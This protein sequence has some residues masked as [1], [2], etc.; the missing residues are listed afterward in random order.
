MAEA[1]I[2]R[3]V[4]G[5][6]EL[7]EL[8]QNYLVA[9]GNTISAG[10]F[11][12]FVN[13]TTTNITFGNESDFHTNGNISLGE[14][15]AINNSQVLVA[16]NIGTTLGVAKIGTISGSSISWG[17]QVTF[18]NGWTS[19]ISCDVMGSRVVISF[20]ALN[21]SSRGYTVAGTIS[22]SSI[23]FGSVQ[24]H[25]GVNVA[26]EN[27]VRLTTSNQAVVGWYN[28]SSQSGQMR[29]VTISG[30][31]VSFG[32]IENFGSTWG[33]PK[34]TVLSSNKIALVRRIRSFSPHAGQFQ[35]YTISGTNFTYQSDAIFVAATSDF[36]IQDIITISPTKAVVLYGDN[37]LNSTMA[38]VIEVSPSNVLTLGTPVAYVSGTR[39]TKGVGTSLEFITIAYSRPNP[40]TSAGF[41]IAGNITGNS[42]TFGTE[43]L[44][45]SNDVQSL[46]I[47]QINNTQTVLAYVMGSGPSSLARSRVRTSQ[48]NVANTNAEKVSG[49][50]KTGGTAGQTI[51]V[52][53][54]T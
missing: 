28:N 3:R 8:F 10:T 54:N 5:G 27:S 17:N 40:S 39:N 35:V 41:T 13:N 50:A 6:V 37:S 24:A 31:N 2:T 11:V 30:N 9:A 38:R 23:T 48:L 52:Y 22:G 45:N 20:T 49:L 21:F 36:S 1:I 44:V 25:Q 19:N 16:F 12:D 34:I 47:G 46:A 14:I 33:P 42:I 53:T 29:V 26:T 15:K 32:N 51:E 7:N 4:G 18:N 43:S